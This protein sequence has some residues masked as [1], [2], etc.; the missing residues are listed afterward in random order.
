MVWAGVSLHADDGAV[1][2]A[3]TQ[4]EGLSIAQAGDLVEVVEVV[5][6]P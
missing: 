1:V 5:A 3:G 2:S 6:T 4:H